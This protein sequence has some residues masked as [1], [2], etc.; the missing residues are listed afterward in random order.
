[1]GCTLLI[2][3]GM[4][5]FTETEQ[6][7]AR[8]LLE[9]GSQ[10]I[11]MNAR[12]LAEACSSSPAA[13]VRFSQKLGFKGFTSL[14][15]D[16]ARDSGAAEPGDFQTVI[17]ESDSMETIVR[18]A[19]RIHQRNQDQTFR[20]INLPV[21]SEAVDAL[22]SARRIHLY[23][24]GA[25][26]L[27]AMDFQYKLTRVGFDAS[28]YTDPHTNLYTAALMA[29]DDAVVAISYSGETREVL[30]P[31]EAAS[32][33]GCAVVAITQPNQNSL[34]RLA[35]FPLYIPGEEK[36]FRIGAMTSRTSSLLILDLLYLGMARSDPGRT[37]ENLKKTL[38]IIHS[39]QRE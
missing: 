15:L 6:R 17:R 5:A 4:A 19:E 21:L 35:N 11:H 26:G 14:R 37:E 28:Y 22:R 12:E 30:L 39:Y 2:K 38:D 16:L 25:S 3:E 31:V 8:Y 9:H 27:M 29:P 32:G 24:V 34:S 33:R 23:G 13:V 7:L 20:M 10:A 36:E 18:K 1:M